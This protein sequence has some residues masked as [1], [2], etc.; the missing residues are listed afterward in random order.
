MKKIIF[1][2]AIILLFV[3]GIGSYMVYSKP[4]DYISIDINPSVELGVN[5]F[6]KVVSAKSGE[7]EWEETARRCKGCQS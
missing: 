5:A 4:I 1:G 3:F 6:N 7:Q 2:C